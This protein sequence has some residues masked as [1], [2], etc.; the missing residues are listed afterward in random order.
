ML[1]VIQPSTLSSY[2]VTLNYLFSISVQSTGSCATMH[3]SV[4]PLM[5]KGSRIIVIMIVII[6]IY[7]VPC[8]IFIPF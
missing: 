8:F 7:I 2:A 3:H 6:A 5:N 1:Y 4:S